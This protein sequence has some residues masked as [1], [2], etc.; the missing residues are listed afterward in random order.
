MKSLI[1]L[2]VIAL[3]SSS[4]FAKNITC[5]ATS[6]KN[7]VVI[8]A[9]AQRAGAAA[10]TS[11][12]IY[13]VLQSCYS[14]GIADNNE[15]VDGALIKT[16]ILADAFVANKVAADVLTIRANGESSI[17]VIDVDLKSGQGL[18]AHQIGSQTETVS[19][20]CAL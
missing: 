9:E 17:K 1:V 14:E 3:M 2:S 15:F 7:C 19:L 18:M 6:N 13:A 8:L 12:G 5:H 20:Q 10:N 4:A 11:S 16:K